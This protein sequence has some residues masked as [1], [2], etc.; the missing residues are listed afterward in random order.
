MGWDLG[1]GVQGKSV[2]TGAARTRECG[3]FPFI[4]KA[5]ANPSHVLSDP[6]PEGDA[7]RDRGGHGAREI[8]LVGAQGIIAC[9]RCAMG[10]LGRLACAPSIMC[11]TAAVTSWA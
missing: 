9:G 8:G 6:L 7:L 2:D 11:S 5:R 10:L 3:T 1:V 4:T